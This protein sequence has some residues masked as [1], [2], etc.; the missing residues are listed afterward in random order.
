[1]SQSIRGNG[2][3]I[4]S[5]VVPA[6]VGLLIVACWVGLVATGWQSGIETTVFRTRDIAV[7]SLLSL[8]PL[9]T[10]TA[11]AFRAASMTVRAGVIVTALTISLIVM[12]TK[13]APA[14]WS[15]GLP[16]ATFLRAVAAYGLTL[17]AVLIGHSVLWHGPPSKPSTGPEISSRDTIVAILVT[18]AVALCMPALYVSARCRHDVVA[19]NELLEQSRF[20]EA[21]LAA[22]GLVRLSP[23]MQWRGRAIAALSR[24]LDRQVRALQQEVARPLSGNESPDV[25]LQR[26]R[27]LAMLGQAPQALR[28][29]QLLLDSSDSEA[30]SAAANDLAGTIAE[31]GSH[32]EQARAHH[33]QA[34]EQW[35]ELPKNADSKAGLIRSETRLAYCDRK[36]ARYD[37]AEKEYRQ[38]LELSPTADMHFLLAQFYEDIQQSTKSR[39]HA[40]R[41]MEMDPRN[42]RAEGTKLINKLMIGHFGC[43]GIAS[44]EYS[45]DESR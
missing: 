21:Q 42:Y 43:L 20:G 34:K 33:Q 35:S 30:V 31:S 25:V 13:T 29:L 4:V 11:T 45:R 17:A 41:A 14:A 22:R 19:L 36:L 7:I 3:A 6:V 26:A 38:A 15:D 9:A 2:A 32:W 5:P 1:M 10:L 12:F 23:A 28:V 16:L 44:A 39:S 18:T 24:D 40:R 37:L 8:L 27:S